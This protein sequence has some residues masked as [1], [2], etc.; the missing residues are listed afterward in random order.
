MA[1]NTKYNPEQRK[2]VRRKNDL[3]SLIWNGER[4]I[5]SYKEELE[6]VKEELKGYNGN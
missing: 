1:I 5:V 3:H 6:E 2:L 4:R